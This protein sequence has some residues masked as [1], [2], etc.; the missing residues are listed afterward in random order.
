MKRTYLATIICCC[1]LL[2]SNYILAQKDQYAVKLMEALNA[3][4]SSKTVEIASNVKSVNYRDSD[5]RSLLMIASK[6]G[7][8]EVARILIENGAKLDFQDRNGVTALIFA[9]A[10]GNTEVVKLLVIHGA[11]LN[12]KTRQGKTALMI[13]SQVGNTE[14][15][16]IIQNSQL[17]N[18]PPN[19]KTE[20]SVNNTGVNKSPPKQESKYDLQRD[21]NKIDTTSI[22]KIKPLD[23]DKLL[24][25][26]GVYKRSTEKVYYRDTTSKMTR[27]EKK[28]YQRRMLNDIAINPIYKNNLVFQKEYS[29]YTK[30][31]HMT[32]PMI[33]AGFATMG[34]FNLTGLALVSSNPE[35]S[36]SLHALGIVVPGGCFVLALLSAN[37]Y[38]SH[39]NKLINLYEEYHL[40][41]SVDNTRT[42][43]YFGYTEHGLGFRLVF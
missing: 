15:A 18:I 10:F 17:N 8:T 16:N 40:K 42:I 25:D 41:G 11:N 38:K 7:C 35:L 26:K 37:H 34:V 13:A 20:A 29:G 30:A 5:D 32:L 36:S 4:D 27:E 3:G 1:F 6:N 23:T 22:T 39:K 43:L 33:S 24:L 9:T 12:L 21:I 31:G 2:V 19:L 28:S 14:I